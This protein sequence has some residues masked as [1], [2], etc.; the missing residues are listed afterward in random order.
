VTGA[1]SAQ[2]KASVEDAGNVRQPHDSHLRVACR[3]RDLANTLH[4][5]KRRKTQATPSQSF[6]SF[7]ITSS[8]NQTSKEDDQPCAHHI[9]ERLSKL[10][11]LFER[12]V[13]RKTSIVDTASDV[14]PSPTLV[15]SSEKTDFS[16]PT[17]PADEQSVLSIGDGIVS[18]PTPSCVRVPTG[19]A[20]TEAAWGADMDI[21][22]AAPP[23]GRQAGRVPQT[24]PN[25]HGTGCA[26]SVTARCR[27]HLRVV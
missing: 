11:Q 19:T 2:P 20:L 7:P 5:G 24:R 21:S 3:Q 13:C 12:F 22:A 4:T 10:E 1:R 6:T 27:H 16:L 8:H 14:P 18:L 15:A 17:I 26:A 23:L 25:P 9:G